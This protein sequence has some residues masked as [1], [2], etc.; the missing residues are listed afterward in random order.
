MQ[1]KRFWIARRKF[2]A[3]R[4]VILTQ[5]GGN[6]YPFALVGFLLRSK[7]LPPR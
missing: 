2:E 6:E 1:S 5:H 4:G 7:S 3:P